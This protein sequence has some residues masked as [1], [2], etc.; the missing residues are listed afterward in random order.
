M[1]CFSI[2]LFNFIIICMQVTC[3]IITLTFFTHIRTNSLFL[4]NIL[5][6]WGSRPL[7]T[8]EVY[9]KDCPYNYDPII[10]N[11]FSLS[12]DFDLER[13]NL[14]EERYNRSI[15]RTVDNKT[16]CIQKLSSFGYFKQTFKKHCHQDEKDCGF[17]DT[18][19]NK[20]C[21]PQHKA[22]PINGLALKHKKENKVVSLFSYESSNRS[23]YDHH[24][25]HNISLENNSSLK[26]T[27]SL[28]INYN[29]SLVFSRENT[30]NLS[31]LAIEVDII[32]GII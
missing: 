22:C 32:V 12:C 4:S 31:T 1:K 18:L 28:P 23:S 24:V 26:D 5:D 3:L 20:F 2:V 30:H 8:I 11:K 6:N 16:F 29:Y 17:L 7:M 13:D 21:V 10:L 15:L 27:Y 14:E 19:G 25:T 9:D